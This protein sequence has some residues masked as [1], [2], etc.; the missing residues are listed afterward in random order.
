MIRAAE[1]N[2]T[3]L[4]VAYRLH[5]DKANLRAVELVRSGKLGHPRIFN[6]TFTLQVK[7][8]NIR[9]EK[10]F[11]GGPLWDI[12]IYCINAARYLFRCEPEDVFAFGASSRD[13][14]FREVEES[15]DAILRFPESCLASFSCSFG[16]SDV[17]AYE[18]VGSKG[19]LR[20]SATVGVRLDKFR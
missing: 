12:G 6:S 14:R 2:Q 17:S 19:S 15:V 7:S 13:P 4:M 16:A 5:F 10:D 18:L 20:A 8:N 9:L 1:K 11:G 3:K